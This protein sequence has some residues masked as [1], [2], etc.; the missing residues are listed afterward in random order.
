MTRGRSVKEPAESHRVRLSQRR[1]VTRDESGA[2]LIL[3]LAFIVV[4]SVIGL[5]LTSWATND[6]NNSGKF[7]SVSSLRYAASSVTDVAIQ[8]IRYNPVPV[9]T[10]PSLTPT[11]FGV[12]WT[13]SSGSVSELTISAGTVSG[14]TTVSNPITITVWCNTTEN[15]DSPNTRVVTVKACDGA[16]SSS[17][18]APVLEAV[19]AFDDYPITG[20]PA[21]SQQCN[22]ITPPSC[23]E[24]MTLQSWTWSA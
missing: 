5:A 19:V 14:T 12:C 8:T 9:A 23:G 24:G 11:G 16:N 7:N 21:L 6:L 1:F 4:V 17:T 13:P 3:A 22:L 18:C 2:I 20:L 10:P 15:L